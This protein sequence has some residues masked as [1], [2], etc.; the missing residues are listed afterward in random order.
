MEY[1]DIYDKNGNFTGKKKGKYEKWDNDEYHL[2]TEAWIINSK[3]Q[4][5]VQ[6]RSDKCEILPGIWALTTG[7]VVSGENTRQGCVRELKEE[8]GINV[9]QDECNLVKSYLKNRL[10]MIWDIYFIRKDV[11]LNDV[12]LQKD[13]VAKVKLVNTDEFR[14]MLKEGIMC[15]Y[16]EIYDLLD[17]IDILD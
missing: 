12:V 3:K 5:L 2:A 1:W 6:Q 8:L 15:E 10:G 17:I 16:D 14:D 11:D 9:T 13:E 4:I 7:R